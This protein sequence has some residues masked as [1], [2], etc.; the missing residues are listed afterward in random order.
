MTGV[1]QASAS[2]TD[3]PNGSSKLMRWSNA[4]AEPR[5]VVADHAAG[6][7]LVKIG[8]KVVRHGRYVIFQMA[9]VAVRPNASENGQISPT[10]VWD[11]RGDGNCPN[12]SSALQGARK[13]TNIQASSGVIWGIPAEVKSKI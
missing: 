5:V 8:A 13:T 2:T 9:E 12:C 11:A 1:P 3:N 7:T 10:V 6:K 4:R